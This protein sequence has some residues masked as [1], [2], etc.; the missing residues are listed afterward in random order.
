M[1][2]FLTTTL[3]DSAYFV[4]AVM[5]LALARILLGLTTPIKVDDEL[6]DKD[7]PAFGP[8]LVGY[9]LAVLIVFIGATSGDIEDL[10]TESV[11]VIM[12]MDLAWV[13]GGII[14]LN[15]SRA[16]LDMVVLRKF[17]TRKEIVE[18]RNVG[19]GALEFGTY[20]SSALIIAGALHGQGGSVITALAF[21][22]LGQVTLLIF[23]LLYQVLVPYDLHHELE[24]D[25][26]P[27]GVAY[28]GNMIAAA[29]V[30]MRGLGGDFV[31]W[32]ENLTT[33]GFYVAVA[34]VLVFV[35]RYIIDL[36]LLPGRTFKEEIVDD[37]NINVG[38]LE[39]GVLVGLA[40]VAAFIV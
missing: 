34:V 37:R 7:N 33:F 16:L 40:A 21:W 23:A 15:L 5:T 28:A 1:S 36:L 20:M 4:A 39:G 22:G 25:N 26:A 35:G 30:L 17:S 12:A 24:A 10:K 2:D 11:P 3:L 29:V 31:S 32:T 13:L 19:V 9:Y 14:F 6:S 8:S 18:D 38:Y 27:A